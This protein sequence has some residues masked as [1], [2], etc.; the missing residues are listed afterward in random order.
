MLA[1]TPPRSV[2]DTKPVAVQVV[3]Q[4]KSGAVNQHVIVVDA[5]TV[6]VAPPKAK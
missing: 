3:K 4:H 2:Y 1:P 5:R 6:S